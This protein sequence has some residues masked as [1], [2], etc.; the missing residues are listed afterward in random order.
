M[1]DAAGMPV[2]PRRPR[3]PDVSPVGSGPNSGR[4]NVSPV[5]SG[6]SGRPNVSPVGGAPQPPASYPADLDPKPLRGAPTGT[7]RKPSAFLNWAC[8]VLT[9][10]SKPYYWDGGN[11]FSGWCSK[12]GPGC[13]NIDAC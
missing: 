6:P 12:D 9:G 7:Y 8:G 10:G 4:P 11:A 1:V 5:G 3:K 13:G 2:S